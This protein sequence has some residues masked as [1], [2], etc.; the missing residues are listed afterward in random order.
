MGTQD[1]K[2]D[3]E[4]EHLRAFTKHLLADV[5]ALE[6]MIEDGAIETDVRRIGAEQEMVLVDSNGQPSPVSMEVLAELNDEHFTTELAKFNIECNLDPFVFGGNCLRKMENQLT[7]MMLKARQA[8]QTCG[9]DVLLTGILP[10][11]AQTHT[12]LD[13]ITPMPRY[14][15]LNDAL[16]RLRGGD[17]EFRLTGVDEMIIKQ[18][19]VMLEACNTSFQVHF[20]VSPDEFARR[21]NIAQ[22]VAGPALAVGTN[23]PLLFGKRLWRE[24]RIGLFQQAVDTRSATHTADERKPRV[25]FGQQWVESS[26]LEIFREDIT[27]FRVLFG[28]DSHEDPFAALAEGRVPKLQS[29]RL[30][31]GTVYRWNRPCYGISDN[32]PHIRIEN[33]VLPAGPTII[34]SIAN[35]AFWFGLMSGVSLEYDDITKVMDFDDAKANFLSAARHGLHA[36]F[37]WIDHEQPVPAQELIRNKLLPL[38]RKGLENA[39]IDAADVDRYLNVI[40]G[41]LNTGRTGAQWLI[42]SLA[43]MKGETTAAVRLASVTRTALDRQWQ[44]EPVHTWP[45]ASLDRS[46]AV[47][48]GYRRVEQYMTTDLFTVNEDDSVDLVAN[49]MVWQGVRHVPVEDSQHRLVG[50][51]SYRQI[52]RLIGDQKPGTNS[53]N[54]AVSA[55]MRENPLTVSPETKTLD[56][57]S[58]MLEHKVS[59]LPVVKNDNLVGIVSDHDFLEVAAEL[60]KKELTE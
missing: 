10:T 47:K 24:T 7:E 32:K 2:T 50:L 33:R 15:A 13:W 27:R 39:N 54:V 25:S 9:A 36:Q 46:D 52:L 1:L 22:A 48:R 42:Q 38:A 6:Q 45:L 18:D 58:M 59:C 11:L 8:A 37:T 53:E 56:A 19:T 30:H 23:S 14:Y 49:M 16:G 28:S 29:L 26:V 40:E 51:V 12:T 5:R 17:Y 43:K 35:A 4:G 60:F 55:V 44:G 31:N 41:R 20:Q 34:D 57:I 21:Y 3:S